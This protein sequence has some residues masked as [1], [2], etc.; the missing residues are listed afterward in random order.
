LDPGSFEDKVTV[1]EPAL[2]TYYQNNQ[3]RYM[4]PEQR[5]TAYVLLN[6]EDLEKEI[7]PTEDEIKSYYEDNLTRFTQDKQARARHILFRIKPDAP[8][9]EA[10]KV[11]AQARKVLDEARKGTDFGELAKKHSQ[12]EATTEKGGELGFFP[13]KQMD[14]AFSKA[15][16]A[17]QPGEMSDLVRTPYGFHIIKL[18]E[19]REA[20]TAPIEEVKGEIEKE[21]KSQSA[22]D[23]AFKQARNLRDL[24][25]ARKDIAK[26]AQEMKMT[27][28]DPVWIT[29]SENQ[30]DPGPLPESVKTKL[31]QLGQDDVSEMLEL[32]KGFVVAQVKSIKRPQPIPFENAKDKVTADFRAARAKELAQKRAAEILAEAKEKK[33]LADV[34]KAQKINLRQ[35]ELFSRRYPDKDLKLHRGA[36]L[37][38]MFSLDDSKPFPDSPLE[39]G[40]GFMICQFQEKKPAGDPSEAEKDDISSEILRQK[41]T[42][43]WKAW[44][45]EIGKATRVERLKEI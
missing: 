5:E 20:R 8:E 42:A 31:F 34:A 38:S 10:E 7:H 17:L 26:A 11:R 44:L 30:S 12:D 24:A 13:F 1:E 45:T 32:P 15:A 39:L 25:Y 33:S 6:E 43:I 4:Q 9:A 29:M 21:I 19:I 35:S 40:S 14:P 23:L 18:E 28:S 2:Q 41:Q 27:V 36:S 3:S 16:F 22:R 37:N